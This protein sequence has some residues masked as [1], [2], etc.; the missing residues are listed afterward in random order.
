VSVLSRPDGIIERVLLW[1]LPILD[2]SSYGLSLPLANPLPAER[3]RNPLPE[4]QFIEENGSIDTALVAKT[5]RG[6][7]FQ[8]TGLA[9]EPYHKKPR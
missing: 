1:I 3:Y 8:A 2:V 6:R 9:I 7:V 4:L 5:I